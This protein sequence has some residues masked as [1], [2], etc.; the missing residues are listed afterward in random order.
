MN[1]ET[2]R[3]QE[4]LEIA[5]LAKLV[6]SEYETVRTHLKG[7][8]KPGEEMM[9]KYFK[10][11]SGKVTPNDWILTNINGSVKQHHIYTPSKDKE[12]ASQQN[13][14]SREMTAGKTA[15][16]QQKGT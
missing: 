6:G 8:R 2:W 15:S 4:N 13:S 16:T 12:L 11:T 10:V 5:E 14:H 9:N 7:T 3:N 1:L